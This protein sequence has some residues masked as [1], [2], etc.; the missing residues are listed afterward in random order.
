R[1]ADGISHWWK[2]N[3]KVPAILYSSDVKPR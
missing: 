2:N 1:E 3:G